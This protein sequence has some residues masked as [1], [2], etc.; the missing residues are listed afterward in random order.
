[1]TD[2]MKTMLQELKA[3]LVQ[4]SPGKCSSDLRQCL[5]SFSDFELDPSSAMLKTLSLD[6]ANAISSLN[7]YQEQLRNA[8]LS[9][10]ACLCSIQ[11]KYST[12][13]LDK[14]VSH[15][16]SQRFSLGTLGP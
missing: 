6:T 12:S 10:E 16:S 14:E 15:I 4:I 8:A 5:T 1:M 2:Q 3:L 7:R 11:K 13:K 9:L